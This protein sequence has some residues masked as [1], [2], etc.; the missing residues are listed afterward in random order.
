MYEDDNEHKFSYEVAP[1][2]DGWSMFRGKEYKA[3]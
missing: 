3:K 2:Y 1:I